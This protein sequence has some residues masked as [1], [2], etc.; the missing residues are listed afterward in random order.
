MVSHI[1]FFA[2]LL[3]G[4]NPIQDIDTYLRELHEDGKLNGTVLVMQHDRVLY[5]NSFGY[6]DGAKKHLLTSEYR[7]AIGSIYKEFPAVAI[8]QLKERGL[9]TLE[10]SLS[11]FLPHLPVWANKITVKNL[12]QYSSGL[13]EIDWDSYFQQGIRVKE[14]AIVQDLSKLEKLEFEP[15]TDYLYSN[16]N[17]FLL[18]RIVESLTEMK[19]KAYVEQNILLPYQIEGVVIKEEY[20]YKDAHL[21]AI[22]F[23][24]NF[25]ADDYE[26]EITTICSSA[27][28]MYRWFVMLDDFKIISK[29]SMQQLSE[30]AKRGDN[31]QA[32]IGRGD[33]EGDDLKMHLHHG[34]SQNYECLVR[35]YKQEGLMVVLMTNQKHGNVH[36][37]A[38]NI[39]DFYQQESI[40]KK[41]AVSK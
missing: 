7:F 22:P 38:D 2:T 17:P 1:L 20:P 4:C 11:R 36:D 18:M 19:F 10:D 28:G 40:N 13:P 14:R 33:W 12:L 41:R 24:E 5:E 26:A 39:V 8:M 25:K 9:L 32:P 35:N 27:T 29:E 23:D 30:E 16:Y 15:G 37:I 6:A 3:L 21:M 34:S 31:I